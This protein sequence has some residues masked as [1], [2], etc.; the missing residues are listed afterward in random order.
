MDDADD[1]SLT[2]AE[3]LANPA[4]RL[5]LA[6]SYLRHVGQN[7]TPQHPVAVRPAVEAFFGI[8]PDNDADYFAVVAGLMQLPISARSQIQSLEK[9]PVRRNILLRPY[10]A[11]EAAIPRV[12]SRRQGLH[13]VLAG[14]DSGVMN[15]L[16]AGSSI[17]LEHARS[18][19]LQKEALADI[20]TLAD[21]VIRAIAEANDLPR[22]LRETLRAHASAI[23]VAVDTYRVHG[24]DQIIAEMDTVTG[25]LVRNAPRVPGF[26]THP[27]VE[28]ITK[29]SQVI[30]SLTII[31]SA[32]FALV[33][34]I[35]H[36]AELVA[37]PTVVDAPAGTDIVDAEIVEDDTP[38]KSS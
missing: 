3:H 31:I 30:T 35:E 11:I 7:S 22:D 38:N 20:R 18:K 19:P 32:P 26:L 28:K 25:V 4:G 16:E 8:T 15:D 17:L 34:G 33:S 36:L 37:T 29:L 6:F 12:V 9:L 27:V 24:T 2:E 21:Q 13:D 23:V 14:V 10:P 5:W 1:D